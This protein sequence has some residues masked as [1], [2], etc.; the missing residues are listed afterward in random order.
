MREKS[1]IV[2]QKTLK[3]V[4]QKAVTGKKN[5]KNQWKVLPLSYGFTI[6]ICGKLG[7]KNQ[8]KLKKKYEP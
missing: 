4:F 2:G 7:C 8:L 1:N 6:S 5:L 3:D